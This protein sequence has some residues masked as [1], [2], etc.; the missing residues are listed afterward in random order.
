VFTG[1][2]ETQ[3]MVHA[4]VVM[5]DDLSLE[6]DADGFESSAI[7]V[8]DS[9]SVSGV[10]LTAVRAQGTRFSF[11]ISKETL[12]R[13][14]LGKL[15]EGE[16]V[17]LELAMTATDRFGGH[18]VAG[19][20]DGTGDVKER[21]VVARSVEIAFRCD[22]VLAPYMAEKG[23]VCVDGVSLT[24]NRVIDEKDYSRFEVSVI[25]HTLERTTLGELMI[26]DK[27]HIE[28]DQVARYIKR[29]HDCNNWDPKS[30]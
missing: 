26:G 22:R 2:V 11:D 8:G 19:H 6:V 28:V 16:K 7:Q 25:P 5:G 18:M 9:I 3:G 17:N 21:K 12:E 20:V 13:T 24:I 14:Q 1:I 10:C 30:F 29:I 27:V 23:S 4:R 15:L